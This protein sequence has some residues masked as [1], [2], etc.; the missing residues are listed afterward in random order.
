MRRYRFFLGFTLALLTVSAC[1]PEVR[2]AHKKPDDW[3]HLN[4]KGSALP[5]DATSATHPPFG[6]DSRDLINFTC[7]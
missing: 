2:E 4:I 1:S 7:E 5:S 6:C 3:K